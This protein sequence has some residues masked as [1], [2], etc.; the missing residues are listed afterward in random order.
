[1]GIAIER[2]PA[3]VALLRRW[4]EMSVAPGVPQWEEIYAGDGRSASHSSN[5]IPVRTHS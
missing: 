3:G 2:E 4:Q 1:M 5:V